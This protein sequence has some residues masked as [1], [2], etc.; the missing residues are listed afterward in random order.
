MASL[1]RLR[2]PFRI[3][4]DNVQLETC[5]PYEI[6]DSSMMTD[7]SFIY[8]TKHRSKDK[9]HWELLKRICSGN[10][11]SAAIEIKTCKNYNQL[12]DQ[13]HR[14]HK[15]MATMDA[16]MRI[17]FN[18]E[19]KSSFWTMAVMYFSAIF[20]RFMVIFNWLRYNMEY[21]IKLRYNK[22]YFQDQ[23]FNCRMRLLEKV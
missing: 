20:Q 10:I 21:W 3:E 13:T 11:K 9:I 18:T 8:A 5:L 16:I 17:V 6:W 15:T 14:I 22:V 23:Q 7:G 19:P 4:L 2:T 12:I 1:E